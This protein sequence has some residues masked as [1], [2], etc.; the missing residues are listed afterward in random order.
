M[1]RRFALSTTT[2]IVVALSITACS[3]EANSN[4][5]G[6][7]NTSVE[8]SAS[9][10]QNEEQ[11][12]P[13]SDIESAVQ[14]F[15][16]ALEDLGIEHT[17][18]VRSEPGLSGAKAVFSLTVNGGDSSINVFPDLE[19]LEMWQELSDGL[20]GIHVQL[21]DTNAVLSLNTDEENIANSAEI[22]P[23]IADAVGGTAHGV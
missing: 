6:A 14:S 10:T 4:S 11:N 19:T 1:N 16:T 21:A 12:Q 8:Q 20:G 22:A 17:E 2:A 9:E 23:Q 15:T 3:E 5:N 7:T 13:A 18:P